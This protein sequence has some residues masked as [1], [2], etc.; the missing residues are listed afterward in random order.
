MRPAAVDRCEELTD[1]G[2]TIPT[3]E[4]PRGCGA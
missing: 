4:V 3:P 1:A 2:S